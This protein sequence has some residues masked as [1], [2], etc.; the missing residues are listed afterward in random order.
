LLAVTGE[1]DGAIIGAAV[2]LVA[3][4]V[5]AEAVA[6]A[7]FSVNV[8]KLARE[9]NVAAVGGTVLEILAATEALCVKV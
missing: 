2:D 6:V 8:P 4:L 7:F 5:G 3:R 1:V 9:G